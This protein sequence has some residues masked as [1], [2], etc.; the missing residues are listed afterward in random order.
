MPEVTAP[1]APQPQ[2]SETK[3]PEPRASVPAKPS[4][5]RRNRRKVRGV[6]IACVVLAAL[7]AGG[8]FLFRFLTH[9]D[10]VN[11][12]IQFQPVSFGTIQSKVTGSGNAKAKESA[13]ITLTAGGTVQEVLVAAGDPVITGQPLYTIFSKEAQDQVTQAED[14]VAQAREKL[15]NLQRDM[16]EL[17]KEAGNLT[18]RAPFAGKLTEVQNFEI[19]QDVSKGATVATLVN[20][21]RIKLSLYFSYAYENDIQTGQSVEVSIPAVMGTFPGTVEQ[22]NKVNYISPEGAVHFEAVAVFDNPG[23]LT[24]GMAASAVL[25][26]ADGTGIYPYEDAKTEYYEIRTITA[27]AAGPVIKK[28]TLLNYANV[29]EGEALLYL[30]TDTINSSIRDKQ[31]EI[32]EAQEKIDEALEKL[33]DTRK[34]LD[35]FNAVSPIDGTVTSCTLSEGMEVKSGDTVITIANT[36][37]MVVEITVDDRNIAFVQPG[38]VVELSDWNG[39]MYMGAVTAINMAAAESSN[40]MT[41]YPVTLSVDNYDGTLLA[42]MYLDYSFVASQSDD[43]LMVPMQSVKYVSGE[44]GETYSVVFV[45]ADERPENAVDLDIPEAMPGGTPQYPSEKDGFYPVQVETG[46]SDTYNVEIRSGL[47]GDEEVFVQYLVE[48]SWG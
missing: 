27:K 7:A 46:L 38:M 2:A 34:A 42:G 4:G 5:K 24:A 48:Y 6:V 35:N 25:H 11:S 19:D 47:N 37:N 43:C 10:A 23:T 9:Q 45:M 33:G 29:E 40:G 14:Q 32:G 26:T 16:D 8:V 18:V 1:Q 28:G 41:N 20:D 13:A 12:D 30:G 3:K 21:R 31:K 44:D 39:N 17:Q 36:A 22:I 15:S